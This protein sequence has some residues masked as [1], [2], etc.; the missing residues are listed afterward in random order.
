MYKAPDR[1]KHKLFSFINKTT[2]VGFNTAVYP[3]SFD[4]ECV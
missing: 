4:K 2:V 1:L 3:I